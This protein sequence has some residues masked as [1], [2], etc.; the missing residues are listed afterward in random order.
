MGYAGI[1]APNVPLNSDAMFR[2]RSISEISN[3]FVHINHD[4]S[5]CTQEVTIANAEPVVQSIPGYIILKNAPFSLQAAATD[6]NSD[7][8]TYRWEQLYNEAATMIPQSTSTDKPSI[9]TILLSNSPI[10][11]FPAMSTLLINS[12]ARIWEV[13]PTVNRMLNFGVVVGDNNILGGRDR[14]RK[15]IF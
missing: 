1:F 2:Y 15:L 14:S 5:S 7:G 11:Y 3:R 13:L 10:C 8:L 6:A 4:T 12:Y 9:R